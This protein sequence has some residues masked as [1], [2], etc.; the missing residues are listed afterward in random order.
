MKRMILLALG[1][2]LAASPVFAADAVKIGMI[3]T[4]S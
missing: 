3:T 2:C 4:L 1:L